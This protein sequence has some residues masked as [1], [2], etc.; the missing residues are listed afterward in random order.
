MFSVVYQDVDSEMFISNR[1]DMVQIVR[2][3]I[4]VNSPKED[5]DVVIE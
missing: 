2:H 5:F 3:E 4:N 1:C